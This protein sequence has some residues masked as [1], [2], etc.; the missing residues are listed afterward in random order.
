MRRAS[1]RLRRRRRGAVC[2]EPFQI[3]AGDLVVEQPDELTRSPKVEI[4]QAGIAVEQM[5]GSLVD[6]P[7]FVARVSW[8]K[9]LEARR[10]P[11]ARALPLAPCVR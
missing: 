7:A 5:D 1:A 10:R 8:R 4:V 6:D 3:G 2:D 11:S 9:W